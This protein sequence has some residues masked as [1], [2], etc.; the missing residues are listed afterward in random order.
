MEAASALLVN[1]LQG[2]SK[3]CSSVEV[4]NVFRNQSGKRCLR[5]VAIL[6]PPKYF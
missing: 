2:M 6:Q 1:F 5:H 4:L 3:I